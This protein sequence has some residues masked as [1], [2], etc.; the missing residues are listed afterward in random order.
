MA[1]ASDVI[2]RW[3]DQ[4]GTKS[5][6]FLR[7][8]CNIEIDS[9][10]PE[11]IYSYG[12]HFVLAQLIGT[13]EKGFVLINSTKYSVTTSQHQSDIA[14]YIGRSGLRSILLPFVSLRSA[15]ID[16]SSIR[17]V[18]VEDDDWR[19]TPHD[20][21]TYED[22]PEG[23]RDG[24]YHNEWND[25][26]TY[27]TQQHVAGQSVFSAEYQIGWGDPKRAYFVSAFDEQETHQHYFLAQLPPRV[28][29]TSVKDALHL[30][31]PPAVLEADALSKSVIRQGDIFAV[32][33][34]WTTRELT[35]RG[36]QIE[37][38]GR[39]LNTSHVGTEV[40]TFPDL[41]VARG[42]LYHK[43]EGRSP[44]DRFDP[45]HKRQKLGDGKQWHAIVK[46][47]VP[48]GRSWS[49]VGSID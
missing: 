28:K 44:W 1:S 33:T 45:T 48:E 15:G 38:R 16:R 13:R 17:L 7:P 27:Y 5:P 41:A 14:R 29:P 8:R 6:R 30:L 4:V 10:H 31:R 24:A 36:G 49:L 34:D 26:W 19:R 22:I 32:P 12:Y 23:N 25:T 42:C 40:I 18:A 3:V 37:K 20:A 39:L 35:A 11:I 46:N 2:E 21:R 9:I 47:T 43:P